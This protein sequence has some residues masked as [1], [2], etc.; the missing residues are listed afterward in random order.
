MI[1]SLITNLNTD[2]AIL[3]NRVALG[4]KVG[5]AAMSR[6]LEALSIHLFQI[7]DIAHLTNKN[8]F[9]V[10][11]PAID[12]ADDA[13][14]IAV[15]VTSVASPAKIKATIESFEKTD[16]SGRSLKDEYSTLYIFGFCKASKVKNLPLYC[17]VIEPSYLVQRL[18]D[19]NDEEILQQVIEAI[20]NH[21][22]YSSLHPHDDLSCLKIVLGYMG[23]NAVTHSMRHEG[24]LSDMVKGLDEI[25]ELIGKGTVNRRSKS[26]AH[27]EFEDLEIAEFLVDV[28]R[29]IGAIKAIINLRANEHGGGSVTLNQQDM[30]GIDKRKRAISDAANAIAASRDI[31]INVDMHDFT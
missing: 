21:A 3:Q 23:R 9:Q 26:K 31:R 1:R 16:P 10:N 19:L 27:H 12:A 22:D 5:F 30:I 6:L 28:L 14:H 11:F 8:L 4:N 7:L 29:D 24:S 18:I 17:R 13:R 2:I 25:S 20:R 15:Q